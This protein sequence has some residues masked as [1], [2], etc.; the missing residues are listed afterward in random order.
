MRHRFLASIGILA[1]VI[2]VVSLAAV[3]VAGQ[4]P[5]AAANKAKPWTAPR[6]PDGHPDLQGG[7]NYATITPLER[8]SELAGKEVFNDEEAAEFEKRTNAARNVDLNRNTTARGVVNGT[9]ETQDLASAYNEFW[10]DRGTKVVGTKRTS[11]VVDPPDGRIPPLT[12]EA[13]KRE[14]ATAAARQRPAEGP[15]DRPPSE[16]CIHNQRAGPPIGPAGYNNNIQ[17]FQTPGYVA[18]LNEQI[19][20]ARIIP[21]DGRPHLVQSVRQ[22]L[23]DSR[24]R[25]EGN[26]LVVDTINFNGKV[27]FRGSGA[28]LHVVE[29]FTRVDADTLLYEYTVNDPESFTRPW[30]AQLPMAKSQD[31]M[32]EYACH[33]GN[34]GMFGSL[35]GARAVEKAAQEAAKKGSN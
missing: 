2:A 9:A 28:N 30:A 18:I 14:A 7:W 12:P 29:R 16:R 34:Y 10:W 8:P 25:W 20:D 3:P 32:Y 13:Q 4:A 27:N 23:G 26:T 31:L 22:W 33:E 6:T 21:M 1:V 17:L 11:L 35:S 19:H 24:G 15:E 5:T